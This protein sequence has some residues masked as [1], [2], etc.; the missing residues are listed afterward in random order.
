MA[1]ASYVLRVSGDFHILPNLVAFSFQ[2][3]SALQTAEKVGPLHTHAGHFE[4]VRRGWRGNSLYLADFLLKWIFS[5][6]TVEWALW[7]CRAGATWR[8]LGGAGSWG[9]SHK[10][11]PVLA[12][13]CTCHPRPP[14]STQTW[15][16]SDRC[17]CLA[18]LLSLPSLLPP[19][20][21][22]SPCLS[23]PPP[24]PCSSPPRISRHPSSGCGDPTISTR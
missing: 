1:G 17:H 3:N 13:H 2:P 7:E 12:T 8:D 19:P 5:A 4:S 14:T 9:P 16:P 6:L 24:P 15:N 22:P 20:P 10:C 23:N 21:P 11:L 18:G